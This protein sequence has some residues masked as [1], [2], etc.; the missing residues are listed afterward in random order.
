M[1]SRSLSF[2]RKIFDGI[3]PAFAG[4]FGPWISVSVPLVA[5]I[6]HFASSRL[7]II[8]SI[9]DGSWAFCLWVKILLGVDIMLYMVGTMRET[10]TL[11]EKLPDSVF[12]ELIRGIAILDCEYGEDRDYRNYGGYSLI[13]ETL[14][15]VL[16]VKNYVD[17]ESH[18]CEWV[19]FIGKDSGY[20]SALFIMSNDFS[21]MLYLPAAI[22]PDAILRELD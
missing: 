13:A 8:Y 17:Y 15:D 3:C 5:V 7:R 19:T 1:T 21:I 14:E 10:D 18:L 12:T 9:L 6:S 4:C 2:S 11:A 22:A 20:L 16:S